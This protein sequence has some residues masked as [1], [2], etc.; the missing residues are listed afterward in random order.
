MP[1]LAMYRITP[2]TDSAEFEKIC[3]DYLSNRFEGKASLYGR[4]GQ[5]QK[6]IDIVVTL[7][8]F[9]YICAQC[10]DVN[11]VKISDLDS[12]ILKS[13]ECEIPMREF[14]IIV[15]I[16]NDSNLQEYI[17]KKTTER[18]ENGKFP[19]TLLFWD[20]VV[21]YIKNDQNMLRMYYPEF[22]QAEIN[23]IKEASLPSE[24][25]YP[26]RIHSESRLRNLFFDEAVKFRIEEFLCSCPSDGISMELIG[27]SEAFI[28]AVQKLLFRA[29][30]LTVTTVYFKIVDFLGSLNEYCDFLPNVTESIAG[31]IVIATKKFGTIEEQSDL[32]KTENLRKKALDFYR[33]IKDF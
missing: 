12:W 19:V 23:V 25:K 7:K 4:R 16:Q 5:K 9:S 17:C 24:I 10:K 27:D 18:I 2:P 30:M 28:Y 21:H 13:E 15:A 6:G 33:D 20:D 11:T 22:Y 29:P 26:E 1:S 8:D 3:M 31:T 14:I 32:E